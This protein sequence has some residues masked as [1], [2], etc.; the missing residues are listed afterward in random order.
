MNSNFDD[1][2][3]DQDAI[4]MERNSRDFAMR[5]KIIDTNTE[6][7]CDFLR[8]RSGNPQSVVKEVFYPKYTTRERYE[9]CRIK[10]NNREGGFGGLFSVTFTSL[11][12]SHAFFDALTCH[13]GPS[14]G[15]NFTLA[16][17]FVILA[18]FTELEWAAQYG[19]EEGLV[20]V[21]VGLEDTQTLL[22]IFDVALRAAESV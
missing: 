15:T 9:K 2:Y 12:A 4:F 5:S 16:S 14:L 10:T 8:L 18:H 20:R 6:A 1:F 21:S 3:F 17:P 11:S 19:V 13:K 22:S 7:I